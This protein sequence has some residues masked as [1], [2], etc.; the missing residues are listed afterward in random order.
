MLSWQENDDG[1]RE[2]AKA[3]TRKEMT[4]T[5]MAEAQKLSKKLC[6]KI[7]NCAK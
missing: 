3:T 5:Q 6:A 7:E 2:K 4:P 1:I